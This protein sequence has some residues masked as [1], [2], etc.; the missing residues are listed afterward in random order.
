MKLINTFSHLAKKTVTCALLASVITGCN[1]T[2]Q[3]QSAHNESQG[4]Q[5]QFDID[6]PDGT[7]WLMYGLAATGCASKYQTYS[8]GEFYC[9]FS[10]ANTINLV[11]VNNKDEPV[12]PFASALRKIT[13][14]GYLKE[15]V[16]YAYRQSQW[17]KEPGLKTPAYKQWMDNNLPAHKASPLG[18]RVKGQNSAQSGDS[19][20]NAVK[21][22]P[23]FVKETGPIYFANQHVFKDPSFGMSLRYIDDS[24]DDFYV[25]FIIYPKKLYT[26]QSLE[27]NYLVDE[28]SLLKAGILYYVNEGRYSNLQV[29][30][31]QVSD[32]GNFAAGVYTLN[33]NNQ[34]I[35]TL[36][37]LTE[38][39]GVLI[40]VRSSHTTGNDTQY[41]QAIK[42]VI[43][44]LKNNL[45]LAVN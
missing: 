31:E 14:A 3:R 38:H 41:E 22:N 28:M 26:E 32:D 33:N 8:F 43:V 11:T 17:F 20:V 9:A 35:E 24:R 25:D 4:T 1:T 7:F 34:P 12:T 39:Q 18:A 2:G 19:T 30:S 5:I 44:D 10:L 29:V 15:Y 36:A 6:N 42:A 16:F 21:L 27:R 37:Y 40:K 23:S 45:S 13:K